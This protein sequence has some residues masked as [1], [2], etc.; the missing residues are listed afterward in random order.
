MP[1]YN[2][3]IHQQLMKA[4][5]SSGKSNGPY[6]VM[7]SSDRIMSG[8]SGDLLAGKYGPDDIHVFMQNRCNSIMLAMELPVFALSHWF[9]KGC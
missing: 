6:L 9:A 5:P 8:V 2:V 4:R 7:L 1:E 3:S